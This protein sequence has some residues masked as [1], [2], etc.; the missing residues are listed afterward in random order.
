MQEV[1][2][3]NKCDSIAGGVQIVSK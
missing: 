1:A 2:D 3:D